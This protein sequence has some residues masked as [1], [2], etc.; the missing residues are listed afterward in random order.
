MSRSI[1][2][3]DTVWRLKSSFPFSFPLK[4]IEEAVYGSYSDFLM[5]PKNYRNTSFR[6]WCIATVYHRVNP[7]QTQDRN[8]SAPLLFSFQPWGWVWP[9]DPAVLCSHLLCLP[10]LC[11]ILTGLHQCLLSGFQMAT[12]YVQSYTVIRSI[13]HRVCE[14]TGFMQSL[15]SMIY[16]HLL[17]KISCTDQSCE[18]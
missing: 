3:R 5:V 17:W 4:I 2:S 16:S 10:D 15:N 8:L 7:R 12:F 6:G 14:W 1:N 18:I 11:P 13:C 9:P